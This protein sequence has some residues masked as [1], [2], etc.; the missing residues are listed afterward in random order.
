MSFSDGYL[1]LGH[2]RPNAG[3]SK[4]NVM[5]PKK[6]V[7]ESRIWGRLNF[8]THDDQFTISVGN[9]LVMTDDE[10]PYHGGVI[11]VHATAP[12]TKPP[13]V[14]TVI[15][16]DKS[17]VSTKSR[18]GIS[19]T[20]NIELATVN[21]ASF[22]VRPMGGQPLAGKWGLYMGVLNFDPD[23]DFAPKTTYEVVLPQGGLTD[24]VGNALAQEFKST[25]TTQ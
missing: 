16:R 24:L 12:D 13:V 4:I 17:T 2:L 9:L 23:Q 18:V 5:D 6:M 19:F 10:L 3:A 11:A 14:D 7:I 15:P 8:T 20:D 25:F 22:I 1:F 21:Q